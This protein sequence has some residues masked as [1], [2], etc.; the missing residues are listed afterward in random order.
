[1]NHSKT[2]KNL[3]YEEWVLVKDS[4]WKLW[5]KLILDAKKEIHKDL[6]KTLEETKQKL[7]TD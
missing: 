7:E 1:M 4:K 3:S 6:L 5:N 2:M